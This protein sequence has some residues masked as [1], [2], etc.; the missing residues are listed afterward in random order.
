M[1]RFVRIREDV[2]SDVAIV[3]KEIYFPIG[4]ISLSFWQRIIRVSVSLRR[5]RPSKD[6]RAILNSD[7]RR[8]VANKNYRLSANVKGES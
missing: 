8:N 4:D 3:G 1:E 5:I 2:E 6:L 7:R